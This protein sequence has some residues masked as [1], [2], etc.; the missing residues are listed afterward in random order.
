M[1]LSDIK[2]IY[3]FE[4][5]NMYKIGVTNN[6]ANRIASMSTACPTI[7]VL[8]ESDY[9]KNC[10]YVEKVLHDMFAKYKIAGEWFSEVDILLIDKTI[11][12][13]GEIADINK[14]KEIY[15][16]ELKQ[17]GEKIEKCI[18]EFSLLPQLTKNT[19]TNSVEIDFEKGWKLRETDKDFLLNYFRDYVNVL[20]KCCSGDGIEDVCLIISTLEKYGVRKTKD[21]IQIHAKILL[22]AVDG[23]IY[24]YYDSE[25]SKDILYIIENSILCY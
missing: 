20:E 25:Y 23:E 3:V 7:T 12:N 13:I 11:K 22:D 9:I 1:Y 15:Q 6:I 2:K 18:E 21:L 24:K 19:K 4:Y 16:N 8:Y 5:M 14:E 17:F 10:F